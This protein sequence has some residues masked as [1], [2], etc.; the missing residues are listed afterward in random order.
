MTAAITDILSIIN[1]Q[2]WTAQAICPAH[3][4]DIFHP[5]PTD[6][7]TERDAKRICCDCPVNTECL[8]HA[9][10]HDEPHG[11]W[12]GYS[13]RERKDML[14]GSKPPPTISPDCGTYAGAKRHYNHGEQTC[15]PCRRAAAEH[16]RR[17]S[18][19]ASA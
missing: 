3:N 7:A 12:G 13:A 5:M 6:R 17:H 19:G 16:S 2:P 11:V 1:T 9:L 18:H 4:P 15:P 14:R 8:L 10:K